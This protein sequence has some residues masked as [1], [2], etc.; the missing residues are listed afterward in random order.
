MIGLRPLST[1]EAGMACMHASL[2]GS[3]QVVTALTLAGDE[4]AE[5]IRACLRSLF[6]RFEIL[7][8]CIRE[9]EGLLWFCRSED[10]ACI[11]ITEDEPDGILHLDS[12]LE[13]ELADVI[14]PAA[15][16]WRFRICRDRQG[17]ATHLIFA[18]HHA[19]SDGHT[20]KRLLG[21]LLNALGGGPCIPQDEA[22]SMGPGADAYA[23]PPLTPASVRTP[24][25]EE[26]DRDLTIPYARHAP[27]DLRTTKLR[28]ANLAPLQTERIAQYC[29][30]SGITVNALLGA[31]LVQAFCCTAG[32]SASSLATAVSVRNRLRP[33]G[34]IDDLGCFIAVAAMDLE[35]APMPLLARRYSAAL[36]HALD[37]FVP[38]VR[39]HAAIKTGVECLSR[40]TAFRGLAI[41]NIGIVDGLRDYSRLTV[42]EYRS[43]AN[44]VAGNF[45]ASLH[46]RTFAGSLQL[47]VAY[48][49]PL[50]DDTTISQMLAHMTTYLEAL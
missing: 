8:L 34:F 29:R 28:T 47:C 20:T 32:R 40:A 23:R 31:L 49:Q 12:L 15:A 9:H 13:E 27:V 36:K 33:D 24:E 39:S 25:T 4:A 21:A 42:L 30:R 10:F 44:R 14:D 11:R 46:V 19:I 3:T 1:I 16:L 35:A 7:R 6:D 50:M 41:T 17:A 2:P 38:T 5:H 48:P 43:V 26:R 22:E 45:A 18:R 37:D